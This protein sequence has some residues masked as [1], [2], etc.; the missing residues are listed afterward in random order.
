MTST[1]PERPAGSG[2]SHAGRVAAGILLSRIAGFLR[3]RA[4]GHFFGLSALSDVLR[5]A[6]RAPNVLQNLL[7]EGSLSAAFIPI[8]SRFVAADRR[9][10]ARRFAGGILGLLA[11]AALVAVTAGVLC[12]R[13][14]VALLTPGFLEDAA[15]VASG[16]A[17][18]DR[19]AE[20]VAA[21]RL[22]FPMTG[23]IVLSAWA[24]G[25][26]NSH[27]RFFL[28]YVA[29][30]A[31][32][33]A[34]IAALYGASYGLFA[35]FFAGPP[36]PEELLR[37][38]CWGALVGGILQ[39]LVQL[40]QALRL[41]GGLRPSLSLAAPGA[42]E[43]LAAFGPVVAGRGVVQLGGY[44]DL[45]LASFLVQGA[46]A[47]LGPGQYLYML[48]VSLFGMSVAAA[49]L[50]E[51]ARLRAAGESGLV[52]R[53]RGGLTQAAFLTMP[54]LVGY[55]VFGLL[56]VG[57]VYRSGEFGRE[58]SWLVYLVLG[59]YSL[60][61]PASTSS[62]LLQNTF[63][64]L[65]DT[66]TPARI[67][68][69][70]VVVAALVAIPLML[71]LDR[72]AIRDLLA[73]RIDTG[74]ALST[75]GPHLGAIGLALASGLASWLELALLRRALHRRLPSFGLPWRRAGRMLAV[76]LLATLP[77]LALWWLLPPL[78][79]LLSGPLVVGLFALAYLGL[80]PR[81]GVSEAQRWLGRV[82][83]RLPRAPEPRPRG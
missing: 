26:L 52:E 19:Y 66:R 44:L 62:R 79:P 57:A 67:A 50:P 41:L 39:F 10:D 59:G 37:A 65:D 69:L 76:G 42:R 49:E 27:R 36:G 14:L 30:V 60:G 83:S 9:E 11:A 22:I 29:P 12:A 5:T 61:L 28:A 43:A 56:V 64:A 71:L 1:P 45:F 82:R 80:A 16:S 8:Y 35:R 3:E 4:I 73:G 38:A 2:T 40:P 32:N 75:A 24:L 58:E 78:A 51:L 34:I 77:A 48:P 72:L 54:T 15:R 23:F 63:Y 31:W 33:A 70:R 81:M 20:A 68:V 18:V 13:P 74:G 17:T 7:G 53:V 55:L 47:A 6:L 46:I 25:V 21:V